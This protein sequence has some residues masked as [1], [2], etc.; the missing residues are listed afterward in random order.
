M[1]KQNVKCISCNNVKVYLTEVR[2]CA[3]GNLKETENIQ[4]FS[5]DIKRSQELLSIVDRKGN[6]SLH[7]YSKLEV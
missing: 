5:S 4:I 1:T 6:K 2:K 3:G 7:Y